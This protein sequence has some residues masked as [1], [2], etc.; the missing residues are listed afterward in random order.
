MIEAGQVSIVTLN[1]SHWGDLTKQFVHDNSLWTPDLGEMVIVDQGSGIEEV[2]EMLYAAQSY[3]FMKIHPLEKNI[4]FP[5]GCN[6]GFAVSTRDYVIFMNNDIRIN[7]YWIDRVLDVLEENPRSIVGTS[8][9]TNGGWNRFEVGGQFYEVPYLEGWL[10]AMRRESF[11]EIGPFDE[12]FGMGSM[13]DV[14]FC[15]RAQ[16]IGYKLIEVPYLPIVHLRGRTVCDGR[17]DQE[18]ITRGNY[19]ILR[20]RIAGK[21]GR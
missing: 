10:L 11:T 14:E 15:M 19:A 17:L 18:G 2:M 8:L 1:W 6:V 7:G 3:R 20:D 21:L 9:I 13:E 16:A 12:S 5:A 4:G